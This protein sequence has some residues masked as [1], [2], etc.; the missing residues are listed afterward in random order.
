M[1]RWCKLPT[2]MNEPPANV[3]RP[4]PSGMLLTSEQHAKLA[5]AYAKPDPDL[6]PELAEWRQR[7][8]HSFAVLSKCALKR[9]QALEMTQAFFAS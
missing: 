8:A 3:R 4:L 1:G 5:E 7:L 9:E 2:I 6:S